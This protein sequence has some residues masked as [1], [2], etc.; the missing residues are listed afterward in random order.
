[1]INVWKISTHVDLNCMHSNVYIIIC[2]FIWYGQ[3]IVIQNKVHILKRKFLLKRTH[4]STSKK[5]SFKL[6]NLSTF[7][8]SPKTKFDGFENNNNSSS[9][10][11]RTQFPV[12]V[13]CKL[14]F[15]LD[16][17][18]P[19]KVYDRVD[20]LLYYLFYPSWS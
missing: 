1:M 5:Y 10:N 4:F 20:I 16:T 9:K 18:V 7:F 19:F 12:K 15:M 3:N 6:F 11:S 17:C 8:F 14:F 13:Q 2:R